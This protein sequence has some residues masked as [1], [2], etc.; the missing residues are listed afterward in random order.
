VEIDAP[1]DR[2]RSI[3]LLESFYAKDFIPS[4]KRI[5]HDQTSKRKM[6]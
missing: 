5:I 1:Q 2:K 4:R 3:A 6:N